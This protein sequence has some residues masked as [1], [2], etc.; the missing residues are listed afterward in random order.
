LLISKV[1]DFIQQIRGNESQPTDYG[2]TKTE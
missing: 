2:S 1:T